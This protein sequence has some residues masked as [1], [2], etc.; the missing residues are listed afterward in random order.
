MRLF[1]LFLF[2]GITS[3][4]S[5]VVSDNMR[6]VDNGVPRAKIFLNEFICSQSGNPVV[7]DEYR[8]QWHHVPGGLSAP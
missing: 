3:F 6:L 2:S 7:S 1:V 5:A 8:G 4:L